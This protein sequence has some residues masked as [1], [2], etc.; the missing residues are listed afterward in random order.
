MKKLLLS[1]S[2]LFSGSV[3]FAQTA[4]DFTAIDCNGNSHH[5]YEE[6]DS[7]KVVVIAWV[8]PCGGCIAPTFAA[9]DVATSYSVSDSGKVLFWL[10]DDEANTSCSAL[11]SW[12]FSNGINKAIKFS[13]T[14]INQTA[15]GAPGMPK[16]IV[17]GGPGH[18]VFYNENNVIDTSDVE[19]AIDLALLSTNVQNSKVSD[20]NLKIFPNPCM[21]FLA[22]EY[23]L[24]V[25][26][27]VQLNI[28]NSLGEMVWK[29]N[30]ENYF[31]G[32]HEEKINVS[33]LKNGI[34][35]LQI[36]TDKSIHTQKFSLVN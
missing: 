7:G 2:L 36:T 18:S 27:S 24:P 34:Y 15:Y 23:F 10:A 12:A 25:Q 5:L 26:S 32:R 13:D 4:P 21:N 14:N 6:L 9:Y 19:N 3:A 33:K 20:F 16:V 1:I 30:S 35:Y 31:S 22:V 8:M 11:S 29:G 28:F 17:L